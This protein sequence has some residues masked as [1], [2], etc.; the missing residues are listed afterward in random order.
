M[1]RKHKTGDV[2]DLGATSNLVSGDMSGSSLPKS[3]ATKYYLFPQSI[4]VTFEKQGKSD[5]RKE[6]VFLQSF[7][8]FVTPQ[9]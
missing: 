5:Y 6:M 8:T 7:L 4:T 9:T 1:E 3:M 2:C